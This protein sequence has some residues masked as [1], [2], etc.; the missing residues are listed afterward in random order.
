M[1]GTVVIVA[2]SVGQLVNEGEVMAVI[3]AMKMQHEIVAPVAGRV[4][5]VA[6]S[7]GAAV[8]AGAVLV[9]LEP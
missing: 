8:D 7:V 5:E 3:E 1:P 6:V 9:V 2:A 4:G